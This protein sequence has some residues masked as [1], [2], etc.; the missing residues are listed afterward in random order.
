MQTSE[1]CWLRQEEQIIHNT[2]ESNESL[3]VIALC[4]QTRFVAF[5]VHTTESNKESTHYFLSEVL[6]RLDQEKIVILLDNAGWH[7]SNLVLKS[8]MSEV[9]LFNVA[10]CWES[11]L[12]ENTF[13]KMKCLWRK[14]KVAEDMEDEVKTVVKMFR[15]GWSKRGYR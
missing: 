12:I 8:S 15:R 9:L 5:Q 2:I 3:Y 7:Q 14:R 4:S 6:R 1:Y 11:N 10:Y 13:S